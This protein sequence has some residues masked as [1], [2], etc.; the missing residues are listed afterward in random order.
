MQRASKAKNMNKEIQSPKN[1]HRQK[2]KKKKKKSNKKM[3]APGRNLT[4]EQQEALL[5][6][7]NVVGLNDPTEAAS[8]LD[9][10]GWDLNMAAAAFLARNDPEHLA[11]MAQLAAARQYHRPGA[12]ARG[13]NAVR[14]AELADPAG[15]E[16]DPHD[17]YDDDGDSDSDTGDG[18]GSNGGG[19]S[20]GD[21][22]RH[23]G[24]E[25]AVQPS[26]VWRAAALP[27][28]LVARVLA[29]FGHFAP[30]LFGA[31][32][33]GYVGVAKFECSLFF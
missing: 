32:L 23:R 3:N 13:P 20:N 26:L 14:T 22:L 25:D 1:T 28:A 29:L 33:G 6:F 17:V 7:M 27:F 10:Q 18:S 31:R 30:R 4:P 11:A 19:S 24:G 21:G 2:K 8:I 5:T 16:D 12:P 15:L 9:S